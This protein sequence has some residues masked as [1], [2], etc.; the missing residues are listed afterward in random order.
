MSIK[1]G[2]KVA[3]TYEGRFED[4]TVFDSST[5]GDHTH[6]IIFTVGEHQV[7]GGFEENV[8]GLVEGAEK[9]FTIL[10]KDA[11][12]E[13]DE[14]MVRA[15]PKGEITMPRN[16]QP[17]KGMTLMTYTPE[18]QPIQIFV[19]DVTQDEIILDLNHPLAG[20]TLIFKIKVVGINDTVKEPE[21]EHSHH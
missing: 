5:H 17:Q 12:G 3:L 1:Q 20:K 10:P 21:H 9:E 19:K 4:G 2:D 7:I 16:Q 8:I 11:Y 15:V 13:Y 6:P 18:G 14:R